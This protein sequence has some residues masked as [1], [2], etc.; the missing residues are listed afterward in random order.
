[1]IRELDWRQKYTTP[2]SL[3]I[4]NDSIVEKLNNTTEDLDLFRRWLWGPIVMQ[5]ELYAELINQILFEEIPLSGF[6]E[7]LEVK[8]LFGMAFNVAVTTSL[9]TGLLTY[10][11]MYNYWVP[12][13]V[14]TILI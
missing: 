7:L 5:L 8:K 13:I 3:I 10:G 12:I 1:M 11:L 6:Y 4:N 9:A 14:L 2:S